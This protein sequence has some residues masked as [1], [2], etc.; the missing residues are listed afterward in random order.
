MSALIP[1]VSFI[2]GYLLGS[3]NPATYAL[4]RAMWSVAKGRIPSEDVLLTL[5]VYGL[6][7]E[8]ACI[9][10]MQLWGYSEDWTKL[11]LEETKRRLSAEQYTILYWRGELDEK[12][13]LEKMRLLGYDQEEARLFE[14]SARYYPSPAD[15]VRF[16]VREVYTPEIRKK[17]GL[18]EDISDQYIFQSSLH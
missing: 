6:L 11:M 2:G 16:A 13:W 7:D 4:S 14:K 12:T 9:N 8:K 17:Y 5:T 1:I 15:I 10:G 3:D 18:D